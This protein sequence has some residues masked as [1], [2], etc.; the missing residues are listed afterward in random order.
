MVLSILKIK[1]FSSP[2]PKIAGQYIAI[3]HCMND[4]SLSLHIIWSEGEWNG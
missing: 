3:G 4:Q 1:V 2:I